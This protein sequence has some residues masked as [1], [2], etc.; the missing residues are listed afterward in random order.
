VFLKDKGSEELFL[1]VVSVWYDE[2]VLKINSGDGHTT[3]S[4]N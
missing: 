4:L 1:M 2:K 3:M